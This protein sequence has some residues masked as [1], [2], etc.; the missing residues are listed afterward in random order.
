[1]ATQT[2]EFN[3]TSGLTISCKVFEVGSDTVLDTQSASEKTNDKGRYSVAFTDL[4]AEETAVRLNGFVGS[5]G[6][7]ANEIF[8][9]D[10]TTATFYPRSETA[11]GNV[12]SAVENAAAT[13]DAATADHNT[14]GSF[15]A[16][17][18]A[19]VSD[20]E[21][22]VDVSTLADEVAARL[23]GIQLSMSQQQAL[24][25]VKSLAVYQGDD[26][27]DNPIRI[28]IDQSNMAD[29]D[30]DLSSYHLVVSFVAGGESHGFRME[31]EGTGGAHYAEFAPTSAQTEAM[32]SGR[33][34]ALFRIEYGVDKFQTISPG[35]MEV[36]T[37]DVEPGDIDNIGSA[38]APS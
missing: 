17:L 31:I 29:D 2:L 4:V 22:T 1:M 24:A 18:D 19:A 26:Y 35:F 6:G 37:H 34:E 33:H 36:S 25:G 38:T 5:D 7:F 27:T 32:A 30:A 10:E 28:D 13:W 12:P 11:L 15:G 16:N 8:D 14:A 3:A 9:V 21:A 23:A 20:V